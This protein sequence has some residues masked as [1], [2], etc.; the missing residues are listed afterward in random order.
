MDFK[1]KKIRKKN[2]KVKIPLITSIIVII[3][4]AYAIVKLLNFISLAFVLEVAGDELKEDGYGHTNFLL[5]GNGGENHEG[6][7]LTDTIIVASLDKSVNQVSM[8]S[9]PRD[10]YVE[11]PNIGNSRI[12]EVYYNATKKLEDPKKG[13]EYAKDHIENIIGVPIHYWVKADFKGFT[14]LIDAIGGIDIYV[15]EAINDPYYPKDGTFLY[16]PFIISKGQHHLD[17]ETALKYARSRKTTS[18]FDRAKRQQDIIYAIKEKA[19]KTNVLFSKSKITNILRALEKNITTNITI[20]EILTLGATAKDLDQNNITHFLI[21]D[22]PS[23]CGGFLYTPIREFY[24]GMFILLQ[25]GEFPFIHRYA[26]LHLNTP[27]TSREE[28]SIQILNGSKSPGVAAETKQVLKRFCFNI[29]RHGNARNQQIT[30]TTYYYRKKYDENG[31]EENSRPNSL[32]FLQKIIP[33]R[34]SSDIPQKYIELGY[35]ADLIIEL[36]SNYINS[37]Q[38]IEDPFY[39]LPD[40]ELFTTT[41]DETK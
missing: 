12:N 36:G 3:V 39:Y 37:P 25:A 5:L 15:E 21:H 35:T 31:Q 26:D 41:T 32:D 7:D 14:E 34:E 22:D 33:G 2:Y 38:Y 40:A 4:I 11:D 18:D 20:K 19:F 23:Q 24:N 17:G 27:T 16:E 28:L 10:L 1:V 30:E 8:I 6:G 13:L 29:T 9:I